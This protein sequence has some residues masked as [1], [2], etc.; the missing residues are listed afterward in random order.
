MFGLLINLKPSPDESLQG[1]LSRLAGVNG[2]L[3]K[4]LFAAFLGGKDECVNDWIE[5]GG[6]PPSWAPVS[7]ELRR[8]TAKAL[9]VWSLNDKKYCP[10]CL[11]EHGYWR[12]AWDLTLVTTCTVHNLVLKST[13]PECGGR[14]NSDAMQ[15]HSCSTCTHS[16]TQLR[17]IEAPADEGSLWLTSALMARISP[18]T[19]KAEGLE[20]LSLEKLHALATRLAVRS[21]R[22]ERAKPMKVAGTGAIEVAQP[23]AKAAGEILMNWPQGFWDLLNDLRLTRTSELGWKLTSALGPLYGDIF[24][25][26]KAKCF[27]FVRAEFENYLQKSWDAPLAKRNRLLS[28]QTVLQHRWVSM[29]AAAALAGTHKSYVE[30]MLASG[31][32]DS[33]AFTHPSGRVS[34]IVDIH[35]VRAISDRMEK[36]QCLKDTAQTLCLSESRVRQ[37]L[38]ASTIKFYGG[39]PVR[40]EKWLVD[41]DSLVALRP[42]SIRVPTDDDYLTLAYA[43][44]HYLP[45]GRG[46]VEL[47]KAVQAGEVQ[48]YGE[49][50]D[51]ISVG[52]WLIRKADLANWIPNDLR[53]P[54]ARSLV[55][56]CEAAE[57]L[58]VKQEVAYALVRESILPTVT[59]PTGRSIAKMVRLRAVMRFKRGYVLGTE[60]S[61]LLKISPKHVLE[62]LRNNGFK[63]VAGPTIIRSPCRQ[64]IWKRSIKLVHWVTIESDN[65]LAGGDVPPATFVSP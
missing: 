58:G 55:T 20:G 10:N 1:Y 44:K 32:L 16:L 52:Q 38:S 47:I 41:Q 19:P 51:E 62:K 40:G 26:L 3:G 60:L 63:P 42:P 6:F 9:K 18:D 59:C 8:P 53:R 12:E 43:A 64:Y 14:L 21:V 25:G 35:Q 22:P 39:P 7:S 30:R 2:L 13:C 28:E 46:L 27:D 24:I 37:L 45:T 56:I 49:H 34:K 5:Q 65:P 54:F 36:A 31:K 23:L 33:R 48:V 50:L 11:A 57:L 29:G 15:G 4:D 61:N 17:Q